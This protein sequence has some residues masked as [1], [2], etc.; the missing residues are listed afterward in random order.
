MA[1]R[2]KRRSL[3][4]VGGGGMTLEIPDFQAL[5]R[6]LDGLSDDIV[7]AGVHLRLYADLVS[8]VEEFGREFNQTPAFWMLT[9]GAHIDAVHA[10]LMRAYDQGSD[11]LSLPRFLGWLQQTAGTHEP[12]LDAAEV[13][14][15]RKLTIATDPLVKKL[16]SLRGNVFAHR[17]AANVVEAMRL[18]ERF[19]LTLAE[20]TELV[21]R[22]RDLLN[23]YSSHVA[24]VSWAT[25]MVGRDD[26]R[27][28][29]LAVRASCERADADI[30]QEMV[31]SRRTAAP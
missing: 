25:D 28:L 11:V 24:S 16:V 19:G 23:R 27:H 26:Y 18:E 31:E 14:E 15:D 10:R 1:S 5:N 8:D 29:L 21:E 30:E 9:F 7:D 12:P 17:N 22:G 20:L 13:A 2:Q 6:M 4:S 3:G